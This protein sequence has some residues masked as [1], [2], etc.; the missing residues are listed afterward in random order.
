MLY[1]DD[2]S[3]KPSLLGVFDIVHLPL[4]LSFKN[5]EIIRL[6]WALVFLSESVTSISD[7]TFFKCL[8]NII[9]SFSQNL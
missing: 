8:H 9:T 2:T 4:K 7:N 5:F 1:F 3:N 6:I